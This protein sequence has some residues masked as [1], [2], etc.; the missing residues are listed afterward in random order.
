VPKEPCW[1]VWK[2]DGNNTLYNITVLDVGN[3]TIL[4]YGIPP[5]AAPSFV[6]TGPKN[7]TCTQD[8]CNCSGM[9]P[10]WYES[11]QHWFTVM[12]YSPDA[13]EWPTSQD[14]RSYIQNYDTALFYGIAHSGMMH[15]ID[16]GCGFSY[17]PMTIHNWIAD[18]PPMRFTFLASCE[19]M[20]YSGPGYFE[21]EFR[22]GSDSN[23]VVIGYTGMGQANESAWVD[24]LAWQN[25]FFTY[26]SNGW[27]VNYAYPQAGEDIPKPFPYI[28]FAGDE[29]LQL[30]EPGHVGV[31][32]VYRSLPVIEGEVRDVNA[33]L[34][35]NVAVSLYEHGGGLYGS[36]V[37]SPDYCIEVGQT[38]EYWLSGSKAM[39]FSLDTNNMS[40]PRNPYRPDYINIT[41]VTAYNFDF[42]G[43]YGLVCMACNM[44][45][46][47]TSVNRWLFVPI[48]EFAVPHPEWQIHSWKAME[49][50][51]SYQ[52]PG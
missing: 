40:T 33:D 4:G 20:D 41:T 23:A 6:Y 17:H 19:A 13:I 52:F 34:L 32:K 7:I 35:S 12:G 16:A 30:A 5:P 1:I 28:K 31:P 2:R 49:S 45:C 26:M 21:Y 9:W 29:N 44:S 10:D 47:L 48:D 46:A 51:H 8:G 43:D 39:Y 18:Y 22:K 3:G 38:G 11:A 36:D 27:T 37:A 50:V 24:S 42:E 14:V 15:T 25:M